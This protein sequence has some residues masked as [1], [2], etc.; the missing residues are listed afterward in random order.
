MVVDKR[1]STRAH[2]FCQSLAL[3]GSIH[4]GLGFAFD[5][6]VQ[7]QKWCSPKSNRYWAGLI[8]ARRMPEIEI[9]LVEDKH[10]I[11]RMALKV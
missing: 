9:I 1:L 10:P 2:G 6:G 7:S 4:M 11:V 3:E 8:R 5:G